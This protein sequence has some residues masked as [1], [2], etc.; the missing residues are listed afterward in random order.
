MGVWADC[1]LATLPAS[2]KT[3]AAQEEEQQA[4]CIGGGAAGRLNSVLL[5]C[6][7]QRHEA[8]GAPC[9]EQ[10]G[11]DLGMWQGNSCS[12]Q[13]QNCV[14]TRTYMF[15]CQRWQAAVVVCMLNC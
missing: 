5:A 6:S 15:R 8:Q 7:R 1:R 2:G 9:L 11:A 14:C 13:V 12:R 4:G 3:L 10:A